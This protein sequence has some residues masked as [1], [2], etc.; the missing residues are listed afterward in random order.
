MI[1][2]CDDVNEN[3]FLLQ[4]YWEIVTLVLVQNYKSRELF[5]NKNI[6]IGTNEHVG[7][8]LSG[9]KTHLSISYLIIV[10]LRSFRFLWTRGVTVTNSRILNF[11]CISLYNLYKWTQIQIQKRIKMT[12]RTIWSSFIQLLCISN[13]FVILRPGSLQ[14]E[15]QIQ[16]FTF[17]HLCHHVDDV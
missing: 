13:D 3:P 1:E 5:Q 17:L 10:C 12:R 8:H 6:D 2:N 16:N 4:L 15:M 11:R 14:I 7:T 9:Q